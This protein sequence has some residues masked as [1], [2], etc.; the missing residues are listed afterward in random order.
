MANSNCTSK[1]FSIN[2]DQQIYDS[3]DMDQMIKRKSTKKRQ[4][5]TK[6][7][8]LTFG[9]AHEQPRA[10]IQRMRAIVGAYLYM[11][12]D[13][14]NRIFV[15]QVD[16]I[17]AQL[18]NIENALTKSPRTVKRNDGIPD[19]NG[20]IQ[21]RLVVYNKWEHLKLKEKWFSYMDNVYENANKKGQAFM[22]V[23]LKRLQNEYNDN[24]KIQQSDIDKEKNKERQTE[25][26]LEKQLRDNMSDYI[27]KLEA[28]WTKAKDWG[29]PKW[30]S[31]SGSTGV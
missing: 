4:K 7:G 24:K 19:T 2:P 25:L 1:M 23:N 5:G 20:I 17:G 28:Q 11:K 30:N 21:S 6:K 10:A 31:Q 12:E 18:E 22:S 26:K 9:E 27:P 29:K 8:K 13:K 14:V 3:D 15:A 16:R